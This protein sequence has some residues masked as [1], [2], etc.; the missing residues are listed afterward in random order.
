MQSHERIEIHSTCIS[1]WK[2]TL[3]KTHEK[4]DVIL[5]SCST[6]NEIFYYN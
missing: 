1:G 6:N 4:L 2:N 5:I 3:K